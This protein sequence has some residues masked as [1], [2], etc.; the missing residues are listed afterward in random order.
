MKTIQEINEAI[1]SLDTKDDVS[2]GYHT[3]LQLYEFRHLYNACLFNEWSKQGIYNVHKSK[4]HHDGEECFGGG[5]FIVSATTPYGQISNHYP[6]KLWDTFK[7]EEREKAD[8]WDGHTA[9]DVVDRLTKLATMK[10]V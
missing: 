8:E 4:Q 10:A 3:F 2:D 7:C 6:L 1:K 9:E 5:W